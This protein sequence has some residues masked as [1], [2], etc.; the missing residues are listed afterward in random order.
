MGEEEGVRKKSLNAEVRVNEVRGAPRD[1]RRDLLA[2]PGRHRCPGSGLLRP[3]AA[4]AL[5][6][7]VGRRSVVERR[8]EFA[9]Q[10]AKSAIG[11]VEVE[12]SANSVRRASRTARED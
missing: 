6:V 4:E 9:P 8:V 5:L 12:A 1:D 11:A 7:R 2:S 10:G 3:C